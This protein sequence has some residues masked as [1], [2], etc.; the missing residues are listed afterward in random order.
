M[1]STGRLLETQSVTQTVQAIHARRLDG[2]S[3]AAA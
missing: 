1:L 2:L 3:P